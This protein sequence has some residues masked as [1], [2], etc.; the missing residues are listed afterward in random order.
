MGAGA[1]HLT[2]AAAGR[3]PDTADIVVARNR[4]EAWDSGPVTTVPRRLP[5]LTGAIT[6]AVL[7]AACSGAPTASPSPRPGGPASPQSFGLPVG[8]PFT[9]TR[10]G[11]TADVTL[12][13][14]QMREN[15]GADF[16]VAT[17]RY[18]GAAGTFDYH[19]YDWRFR[20]AGG[21]ETQTSFLDV[22]DPLGEGTVR[23][24]EAA[25]GA[26]GFEVPAGTYGT[27]FYLPAG[28]EL[29]SWVYAE[30]PTG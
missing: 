27:V 8:T 21:T 23:A 6:A 7:A 11:S 20:A 3:I 22:P 30:I 25:V 26:V 15:Q 9:D 4:C 28:R 2:R 24:G 29:A 16:L 18:A 10:G 13:S 5:F 14:A 17:V 12:V 19:P 1:G